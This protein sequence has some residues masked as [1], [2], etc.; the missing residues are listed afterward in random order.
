MCHCR[1]K[2][3]IKDT[4]LRCKYRFLVCLGVFFFKIMQSFVDNCKTVIMEV[5]C[6]SYCK[7]KKTPPNIK[8]FL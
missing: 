3:V 7:K 6:I 8:F 5:V 4:T 2:L 1:P